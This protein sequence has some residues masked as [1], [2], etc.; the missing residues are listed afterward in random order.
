MVEKFTSKVI[1]AA[2]RELT[3]EMAN[4]INALGGSA[5]NLIKPE[6]I[7]FLSKTNMLIDKHLT[8]PETVS[9]GKD[10]L[11]NTPDMDDYERQCKKDIADLELV[12][13]QQ[14]V[15]MN[16]LAKEKELYDTKL[17][18]EAAI[19]MGMCDLYEN[20]FTGSN[21]NLEMVDVVARM[22]NDIGVKSTE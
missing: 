17:M 10:S 5:M 9:V 14:A 18:E 6:T 3:V 7:K 19:D 4:K 12:Y 11:Q 13:K 20:N 21:F 15:M 1:D 22:L 2:Q 8:I 16:Y